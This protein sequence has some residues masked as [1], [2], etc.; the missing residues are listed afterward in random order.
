[1]VGRSRAFRLIWVVVVGGVALEIAGVFEVFVD[2]GT[3]SLQVDSRT[4]AHTML[5][6]VWSVRFIASEG[7]PRNLYLTWE[8]KELCEV[9]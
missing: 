8:A 9:F 1:M 3:S 7:Q 2:G 4:L 6:A 5:G